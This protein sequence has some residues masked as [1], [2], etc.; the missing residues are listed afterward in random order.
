M[1]ALILRSS[2]NA[3]SAARSLGRAGL[4]VVVAATGTDP[5][6]R[7]S[8]HVSRM[9]FLPEISDRVVYSRLIDLP[10]QPHRPFL[11]ATGD[12]DAL[13][14]ARHQVQLRERYCFASPSL[15]N[16]ESMIDKAR[17]YEISRENGFAVPDFRVVR[18]EVDVEPAIGA[19][20]PPCYVKPALGHEWRRIRR[21]KL[22]LARSKSE[23]RQALHEFVE[24]GL[25]AIPMEIVPG[26]DDDVYSVSAYIGRN[27]QPIGWRT[28]RKLRQYP[29]RAGNGSAQEICDEPEVARTGLALVELFGHRGPVTVEFRRD[30]RDGSMKLIEINPRTSLCQELITASGFDIP[31]V[32]YHDAKELPL[33]RISEPR[34]RRWVCLGDDFRAYRQLRLDG[35]ITGWQWLASIAGCSDFAYFAWDDPLPFL[36]RCWLWLARSLRRRFRRD[37]QPNL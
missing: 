30:T 15:A 35:S 9:E 32:A 5:A 8:R 7:Y 11:L 22:V 10:R 17:M 20:A 28:K 1:D 25:V 19:I 2:P 33:P 12:Q 14:V 4:E 29:M 37:P 3:L 24:L 16:L 27:G 21:G 6:V 18:S 13:I 31:L 36:A 26:R 34:A 23:L